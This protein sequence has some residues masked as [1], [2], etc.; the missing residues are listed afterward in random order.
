MGCIYRFD[1]LCRKEELIEI[2]RLAGAHARQIGWDAYVE[3]TKK[4]G[5]LLLSELSV[6]AIN[7]WKTISTPETNRDLFVATDSSDSMWGAIGWNIDNQT[8]FVQ[9]SQTWPEKIEKEHIFLKELLAATICIE[10]LCRLHPR[11]R[12]H[13]LTDNTACAAVLRRLA[14]SS[15]AGSDMARR[16]DNALR[17]NG[18]AISVIVVPSAQNP[19]DEPS[20]QLPLNTA[21]LR[22]AQDIIVPFAASFC[23]AKRCAPNEY[24]NAKYPHIRHEE[25]EEEA[26]EVDWYRFD[27]DDDIPSTK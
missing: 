4:H 27:M 5:E 16:V 21:K 22:F 14:S 2:I 1:P 7:D 10:R 15:K 9:H 11:S 18:C 26:N 23:R 12:V 6:A 3:L 8:I 20:R 24:R 13:V 19:A 17:E 25:T